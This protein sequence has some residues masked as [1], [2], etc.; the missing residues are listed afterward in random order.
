VV[1]SSKQLN[2]IIEIIRPNILTKGSNY[3]FEDVIGREVVE[4]CGGRVALIPITK[5]VSST[6]IINNIKRFDVKEG[7]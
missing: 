6:S 4:R 7:V 2:K 5:N 1:F 3:I